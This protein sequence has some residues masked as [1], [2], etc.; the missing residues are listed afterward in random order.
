MQCPIN[1]CKWESKSSLGFGIPTTEGTNTDGHAFLNIHHDLVEIEDIPEEVGK[2]AYDDILDK[3]SL[4]D[5]ILQ[6][7]SIHLID[8][9]LAHPEL[10]NW[11]QPS[12]IHI[13]EFTLEEAL[14]RFMGAKTPHKKTKPDS[15]YIYKLDPKG[16]FEEN[17]QHSSDTP[18][19]RT[20]VNLRLAKATKI[21]PQQEHPEP[22]AE[23]EDLA[24]PPQDNRPKISSILIEDTREVNIGSSEIPRFVHI[25]ASLSQDQANLLFEVLRENIG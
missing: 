4:R 20:K 19:T 23:H 2:R 24:L 6:E 13:D 8:L 17:P 11:D 10:I 21:T 16:Y 7:L 1:A 12:V 9:P 22:Q 3:T 5:S 14:L 18:K 25:A 15:T